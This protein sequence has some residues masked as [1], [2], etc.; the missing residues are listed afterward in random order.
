VRSG[1]SARELLLLNVK[2][3]VEVPPQWEAQCATTASLLRIP[4]ET[5]RSP[6]SVAGACFGQNA[7]SVVSFWSHMT[8]QI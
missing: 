7:L 8:P 5:L 6:V 4:Q 3:L 1:A 2:V